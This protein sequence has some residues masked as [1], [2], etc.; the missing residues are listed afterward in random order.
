MRTASIPAATPSR[1]GPS[2]Q[3]LRLVVFGQ[4]APRQPPELGFPIHYIG[5][6]YDGLNLRASDSPADLL[7]VPSRQKAFR[8]A[9]SEAYA[10]GT[11]V[12]AFRTGGLRDIVDYHRTCY[13]A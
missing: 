10:C 8:Q 13:L 7:V 4:L 3:D 2:L 6:L 12:V 11:P 9:A 5:L 1:G